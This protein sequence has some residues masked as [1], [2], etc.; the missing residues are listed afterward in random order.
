[1]IND[2]QLKE[3]LANSPAE[4][5]T[6]EYMKQR[7]KEIS[8]MNPAGTTTFC[9]ITLDNGYAVHGTSACVNPENFN[10]EIGKKIS[11]DNAFRQLWILFGF[12]L[13]EKNTIKKGE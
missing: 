3:L 2:E 5:V 6:E 1:M 7:I 12:L 13:A 10:K 9:T 8:Y 11:Y 4:R